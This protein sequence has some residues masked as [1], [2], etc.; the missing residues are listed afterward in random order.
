MLKKKLLSVFD[1]KITLTPPPIWIMRQAG[2]YLPEYRKIRE[3]LGGFLDLCYNPEKAAEVTLQP[4][5]RFDL[6]AAIIFSDILILPHS[7]GLNVHFEEGEGP[8][9][10]RILQESDLKKLK[11]D[12]DNE[13]LQRVYEAISLTRATLR[14]DKALI[15]F[16][17]APWTVATYVLEGRGKHDFSYSREVAY[18]NPK[19]VAALIEKLTEQ[20]IH[21]LLSQIKAGADIVQ[22]FDSWAGVL[23]EAEYEE[24]VIKP[25]IQIVKEIKKQYPNTP[26]IGFPRGSGYL[27]EK[28]ISNTGVDAVGLDQNVPISTMAKFQEKIVVQGN[29]DPVVLLSDKETIKK[30]AEDILD[31]VGRN[32]KFIF[33]L[34]HGILPRTPIENVEYLVECVRSKV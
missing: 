27:Y 2:R 23:G 7:M 15:G 19:F 22:I 11:I 30:K 9:V 17:G 14:R 24:F 1:K 20:T 28:Y 31:K 6:D 29:L 26:I 21:H 5:K 33:N 16:V 13:K 32:G 18:S 3:S 25:T 8:V 4:I 10:E 12:K 34:G